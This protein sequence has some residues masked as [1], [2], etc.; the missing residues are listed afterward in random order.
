[1]SRRQS[2]AGAL[3]ARTAA[4]QACL[5]ATLLATVLAS[6]LAGCGER[7]RDTARDAAAAGTQ[8]AGT[9]PP[10]TDAADTAA[11][12]LVV[13]ELDRGPRAAETLAPSDS[14]ATVGQVLFDAKG[15]TGCHEAG[16]AETAPDLRGVTGRRTEAWLRRQLTAPEWMAEHDP[17]TRAMVE[18]YG[19]PMADLDVS[20]D[21]ATA[22]LQYLLRDG[23]AR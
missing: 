13:A 6:A 12:S 23:S 2:Q 20:A 9:T 10:A 5:L 21:E 15:C 7:P 14:L 3:P 19:M 17:L 4:L 22:L 16:S 18:Q 1:M 8:A 11:A